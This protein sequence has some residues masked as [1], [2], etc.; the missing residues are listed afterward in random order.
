L[1]LSVT[2]KGNFPIS[3]EAEDKR[4]IDRIVEADRRREAAG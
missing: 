3:E 2:G 4:F 1:S